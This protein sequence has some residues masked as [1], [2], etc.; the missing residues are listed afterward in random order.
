MYF[1]GLKELF[2]GMESELLEKAKSIDKISDIKDIDKPIA[3]YVEPSTERMNAEYDKPNE[4]DL[5]DNLSDETDI[6]EENNSE[7]ISGCPID[8]HGGKW[9]GTRGNSTWYPDR[10]FTPLNPQTN[11]EKLTWGE[12]LDKY[13]IDGIPFK[14]GEPDF[15]EVSKGTVEIDNF[16][17]YRQG[18]GGNFDQAAEKLAE[19]RGCTK[20]EVKKWMTENKYTWHER[21]DCKTMDKV[22]RE[23]HGNVRHEGGISEINSN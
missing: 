10:D 13:G 8:G 14:D 4:I 2:Q 11:P 21:S 22:P 3:K 6:K 18:K 17:K 12:I 7:K 23:V 16:S 9:D 19:Q 5:M 1:M 20:E 15:S